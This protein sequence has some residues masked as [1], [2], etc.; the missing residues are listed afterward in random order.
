MKDRI[1]TQEDIEDYDN[2]TPEILFCPF[3][4]KVGLEVVLGP[5]VLL[6]QEEKQPDY[7]DF[8]QCTKCARVIP[9]YQAEP[10]ATIQDSVNTIENPFEEQKGQ[11]LS[12]FKKR[13]SKTGKT[14]RKKD[15]N[16]L[17]EDKEVNELMRRY[18]DRVKVVEDTS[19]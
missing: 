11:V 7:S 2:D 13:K 3:C 16:K 5:K 10:E 4:A 12:A 8:L 18:G 15:K 6:P 17:H 14:R 1:I 19:Q 9:I